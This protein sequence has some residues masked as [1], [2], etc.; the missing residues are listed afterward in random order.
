M[1]DVYRFIRSNSDFAPG[2][3]RADYV[4][5]VSAEQDPANSSKFR[6]VLHLGF[7]GTSL[8]ALPT[9]YDTVS[10]ALDAA[11]TLLQGALEFVVVDVAG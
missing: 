7:F 3:I 4:S 2:L 11:V 8:V 5:S 10:D 6:A 1:S 9:Q